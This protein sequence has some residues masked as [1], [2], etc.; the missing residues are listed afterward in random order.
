[1]AVMR[2]ESRMPRSETPLRSDLFPE[3]SPYASGMLAVDGRHT[4]YW[5]QSGNPDGVP[6]VFLHGGPGAGSAP[7]HRRLLRSA[8]LPH[9]RVRP[10]RLRPLDAA[11]RA[12]R[13]HHRPSR[14][15]HG[16][17]ARPSRHPAAG[18]CS[19]ARG[20]ARWRWPM[21]DPSRAR[22]RLHPARHLPRRAHGDR[23]VPPRHARDLP[24]GVARLRRASAGGRARRSAWATT[25]AA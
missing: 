14:R 2:T 22:H 5:E 11:R 15:R 6:V 8:I 1:M 13:Q 9:R 19:A 20:A 16:E 17:A 23:L 18:C 12:A 3:I 10:A 7:V 25:I 24:R 4:I 21:A